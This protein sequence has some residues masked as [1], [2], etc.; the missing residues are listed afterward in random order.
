M[1]LTYKGE[2]SSVKI[3]GVLFPKNEQVELS[4]DQA[5]AFKDDRF[6]K[7]FLDDGTIV[8]TKDDAKTETKTDAKAQAKK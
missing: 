2:N 6:G 4:A 1:K 7:H 3:A 8:E 5:K